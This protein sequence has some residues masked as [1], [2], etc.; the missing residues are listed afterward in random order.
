MG[1]GKGSGVGQSGRTGLG[2]P[3]GSTPVSQMT[4][5]ERLAE[6]TDL[7][8]WAG[9]LSADRIPGT[10]ERIFSVIDRLEALGAGRLY[11][12]GLRGT[13]RGATMIS[14]APVFPGDR[15]RVIREG[16]ALRLPGESARQMTVIRKAEVV[17]DDA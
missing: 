12:D 16:Y 15:V 17:P 10:D 4:R 14:K 8:M 9:A 2:P 3:V 6:V 13:F 11:E 1:R 7:L 5:A